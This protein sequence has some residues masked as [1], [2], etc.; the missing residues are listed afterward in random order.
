M[1]S[2]GE[3]K[4]IQDLRQVWP[5]EALDFTRWLAES[6]NLAR[7]GE[8]IGV[9][10]ED[11]EVESAVGDFHV[12]I[13]TSDASTGQ[14]III[15]NQLESTDH[16]HLGKIITYASGKSANLIVWIVKHAR[17]EHRSAIEWLNNHTD[18]Q[19]GFFLCEV[20]LYCIGD[21]A[22]AV[23]FEIIEEPN[24]WARAIKKN[25]SNTKIKQERIDYWQAFNNYAAN[26]QNFMRD[27]NLRKPSGDH[28]MNLSIGSSKYHLAFCQLRREGY[29]T[30]DV[31][32]SEDKEIF[33]QLLKY[34]TEFE[35]ETGLH[36]DWQELPNKAASRI[37]ARRRA[38]F[39]NRDSWEQQFDWVIESAIKLKH[40]IR[41]YL[42]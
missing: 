27:F 25:D 35:A 8:T 2:L 34:R 28:W 20:K 32:I 30:L 23:K 5:H 9:D 6:H 39:A 11:A 3:L 4:E 15:E 40:A 26:N 31:Y 14:K 16:D 41:K 42:K 1:I 13:F 7:L 38:D 18:D 37:R 33:H 12:D 19:I 24:D 21:S 17:E 29:I 36:F 10:L 22:P